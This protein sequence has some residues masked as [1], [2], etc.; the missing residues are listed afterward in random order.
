MTG[1]ITLRGR[2]LAV[3]GIREKVLAAVRAGVGSVIIPAENV[4]DLDDVP[5]EALEQ[6]DVH[7]VSDVAQA[8][9][10]ALV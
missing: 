3:G 10:I 5:K 1:E 6:I 4:P 2:V 9:S 8:L 7:P